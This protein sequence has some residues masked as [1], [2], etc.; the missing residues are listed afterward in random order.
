MDKYILTEKDLFDENDN[1][2]F[3][4]L[5]GLMDNKIIEKNYEKIGEKY[6]VN[7]M[8]LLSEFG[9]K[10]E[11]YEISYYTLN[12]FINNKGEQ[13]D[14]EVKLLE[15]IYYIY[16]LDK[17]KAKRVFGLLKTKLKE[18]QHILDKYEKM[19]KYF[20]MF[21]PKSKINQ[22]NDIVS[23]IKDI[24]NSK[25]LKTYDEKYKSDMANYE[26]YYEEAFKMDTYLQSMFFMQIFKETK[27][28]YENYKNEDKYYLSET[29]N[30]FNQ[31]KILFEKDGFTK[32]NQQILE[33]CIRAIKENPTQLKKEIEILEKILNLDENI[34]INKI[35]EEL[36]LL[37]Q[38]DQIFNIS[39][40]IITF[41][42][43]IKTKETNLT[44]DLKN[45]IN[46]LKEKEEI[47][48]IKV[49]KQKLE[50][51]GIDI[52][53]D[54]DNSDSKYLMILTELNKNKECI[55]FLFNT[56]LEDC[57]KLK[58]LS[59][60]SDNNIVSTNDILDMEKCIE[61]LLDFKQLKENEKTDLE[62]V[63]L[64]KQKIIEK[65]KIILYFKK[66]NK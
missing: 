40:S 37:S 63:N 45:I 55:D 60:E 32:I 54:K 31:I 9:N 29:M 2:N 12:K 7:T 21:F 38:K 59:L 10:L 39:V 27:K 52:Y 18:V 4:I 11:N 35:S 15:I 44:S 23:I 64:L 49:S 22:I 43:E 47:E 25:S 61:F 56:S 58:E 36:L 19:L 5:K 1:D 66:Y 14:K 33:I 8:K 34:D 13:N 48:V 24:T 20:N 62:I 57:G 41:L 30:K 28:Q 3:I 42:T 53:F 26:K 46:N 6:I 17:E 16:I 65:E 50:E 51:Y